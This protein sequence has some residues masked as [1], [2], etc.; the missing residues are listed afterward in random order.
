MDLWETFQNEDIQLALIHGGSA[1][2]AYAAF[3]IIK[4]D[5]RVYYTATAKILL[6]I[7]MVAITFSPGKFSS[8]IKILVIFYIST[9]VFAGAS[10]ALMYLNSYGAFIKNGMIYM[11]WQ[12]KW[13]TIFLSI[14]TAIIILKVFQELIQYRLIKE[15]LLIKLRIKFG[16]KQTDIAALIDTGNSLY[17]PLSNM[18]V[19]VVEF[20]AIKDIL[21]SEICNIFED[22]LESDFTLITDKLYSSKWSNRVRLIPFTSLGKE[23]GM[24]IGFKPDYVEIGDED[25]EIKG[26]SDVII[27]IY[28]NALSK[29]RKYKALLSP[30]LV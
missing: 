7:S 8:F 19:I 20:N 11:Y 26:I 6:S 2:A 16:S 9:F 18:P 13:T 14:V 30:D 4:P 29:E 28:N 1:G 24:L 27:G 23:N 3:L 17:D 5:I 15:K 12:S 10:F 22:S 21:P 25:T